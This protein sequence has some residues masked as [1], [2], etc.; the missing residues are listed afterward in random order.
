[1]DGSDAAAKF[2]SERFPTSI[3]KSQIILPGTASALIQQF[4]AANEQL[5]TITEQ[6][7]EAENLLKQMMGD[8]EV[9]TTGDRIITWKS[10]SQERLDSKTLKAEHPVLFKKYA[11]QTSYRRF[12]I[13]AAV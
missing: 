9:G 11:N 4:E 5:A 1:L 2:I 7:Q 13:K 12:S 8:N 10:V 3:P 6:K